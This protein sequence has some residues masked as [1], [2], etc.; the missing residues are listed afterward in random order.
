M[1]SPG[2]HSGSG[3]ATP[4]ISSLDV[5]G[6][7]HGQVVT[8]GRREPRLKLSEKE[9]CQ[10]WQR[11]LE[12]VMANRR[13]KERLWHQ[14]LH[15]Y[16]VAFLEAEARRSDLYKSLRELNKLACG[17]DSSAGSGHRIRITFDSLQR[18]MEEQ[19]RTRLKQVSQVSVQVAL[20]KGD[21]TKLKSRLEKREEDFLDANA[22]GNA[23]SQVNYLKKH[24]E[25]EEV[26][27]RVED[28]GKV[29]ASLRQKLDSNRRKLNRLEEEQ[30]HKGTRLEELKSQ[31]VMLEEDLTR[32]SS[33]N[34][35]ITSHVNQQNA[36]TRRRLQALKDNSKK[37]MITVEEYL[38]LN[39][40]VQMLEKE[41]KR[42]SK[43]ADTL[44]C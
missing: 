33:S 6:L 16:Q 41:V 9:K 15:K 27:T 13:K 29:L 10:L 4:T 24:L 42:W 25:H 20:L 22:E 30:Q 8:R 43:K 44:R 34:S 18:F 39:S 19:V 35:R 2:S 36:T 12:I 40:K 37:P 14:E 21:L 1:D 23:T 32:L 31:A 3:T 26:K 5:R 7:W 38:K 17:Q 28:N 11:E